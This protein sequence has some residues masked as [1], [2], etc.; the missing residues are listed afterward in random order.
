MWDPIRNSE[1]RFSQDAAHRSIKVLSPTDRMQRC[2]TNI[3]IEMSSAQRNTAK[4]LIPSVS[5]MYVLTAVWSVFLHYII[6]LI[7]S[8]KNLDYKT[9]LVKHRTC[10]LEIHMD[11]VSPSVFHCISKSNGNKS[12][13]RLLIILTCPCNVD[14]FTPY[15]YIVKLEFTG[16]Y[17]FSSSCFGLKH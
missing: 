5:M 12:Y 13:R 3:S 11:G 15:F 7:I 4:R 1:D 9:L 8:M 6:Q 17:I 2:F 10:L 14:P 16:V